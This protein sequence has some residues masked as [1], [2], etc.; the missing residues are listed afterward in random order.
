MRSS[1][2]SKRLRT[3]SMRRSNRSPSWRRM[4]CGRAA[5]ESPLVSVEN[6]SSGL[7]DFVS[8]GS[9][10]AD[11]RS[12]CSPP[13]VVSSSLGCRVSS[14]R[15]NLVPNRKPNACVS[16]GALDRWSPRDRPYPPGP[17]SPSG[18][19]LRL[20]PQPAHGGRPAFVPRTT[21]RRQEM[22]GTAGASN[23]HV[24]NQIRA[25]PQVVRSIPRTLSRWRHGF[26]PRWDYNC[27]VP[28]QGTSHVSM[29]WLNTDSN[30]E[31][32]ANIRARSSVASAQE[33]ARIEG[34]C[35]SRP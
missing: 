26:E 7:A 25:S 19:S 24:R 17:G 18:F 23:P 16:R 28:G 9:V 27:K 13:C 20:R 33:S 6:R 35:T 5:S 11:T 14:H 30:P 12:M 8:I 2:S 1:A 31:Y 34:G 32:P 3:G 21:G 4:S 10:V 15:R 29:S 22:T